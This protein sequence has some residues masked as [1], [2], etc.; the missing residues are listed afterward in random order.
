MIIGLEIQGSDRNH[1]PTDEYLIK[2]KLRDQYST[3]YVYKKNKTHYDES[4]L[5]CLK[6]KGIEIVNYIYGY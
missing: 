2:D 3:A 1:F 5:L 4:D 6:L